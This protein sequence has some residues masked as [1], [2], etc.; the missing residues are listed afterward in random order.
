MT[1]G[2]PQVGIA[3]VRGLDWKHSSFCNINYFLVYLLGILFSV[4]P[5]PFHF[6]FMGEIFKNLYGSK[7]VAIFLPPLCPSL[8]A[9]ISLPLALSPPPNVLLPALLDRAQHPA[10]PVVQNQSTLTALGS[11]FLLLESSA[12]LDFLLHLKSLVK[13]INLYLILIEFTF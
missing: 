6:L 8:S 5:L 11:H 4:G 12:L 2:F 1:L 10:A 9:V 7:S 3:L 13:K